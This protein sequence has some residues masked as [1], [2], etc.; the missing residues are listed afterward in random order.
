MVTRRS[1][2]SRRSSGESRGPRADR[3]GK[4]QVFCP[5]C[6]TAFRV[7]SEN[8]DLR[9]K[10]SHCARLFVAK[11]A[12]KPASNAKEK[13]MYW[14]VGGLLVVVL[15]IGIA[16]KSMGGD[17][18]AAEQK[19]AAELS[20]PRKTPI[21]DRNPRVSDVKKWFEGMSNGRELD[22]ESTC[23][24]DRMKDQLGLA[25]GKLLGNLPDSERASLRMQIVAA[26]TKGPETALFRDLTWGYG[27][28]GSENQATG[29]SG[30]VEADLNPKD[31]KKYR[32]GGR[33]KIA[34]ESQKD[35]SSA[36]VVR[37]EFLQK[38]E[39]KTD[40]AKAASAHKVQKDI[41][42]TKKVVRMIEGKAKTVEEAEIV[43]LAHL[44]DTPEP[45]RQEIDAAIATLI[46]SE[47]GAK[48]VTKARL[49]LAEIGRPAIPRLLTK[50]HELP[51]K[52]PEERLS[53]NQIVRLLV[54]MTN[55]AYGYAPD[56]ASATEE[57]R[58]SALKRYY[59]WWTNNH[60]RYTGKPKLEE[61]DVGTF[62]GAKPSRPKIPSD[63]SKQPEPKK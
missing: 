27:Q 40:V 37:W 26:L 7:P 47:K 9:I 46:D 55:Q 5:D 39:L 21:D 49:R 48:E 58:T 30:E 61:E 59:A 20:T 15:G 56:D 34:F 22:I 62:G 44:E 3:D 16:I 38:P 45:L 12:L 6:G 33:I 43:P 29:S 36:R 31:E 41:G 25:P 32:T 14:L 1:S 13:Q 28:L 18:N 11:T 60:D 10:C 23:D 53:L 2:S 24:L 19:N 8:L 17:S 42:E 57:Q 63:P 52:T 51:G 50:F 4:S 35:A 54:D